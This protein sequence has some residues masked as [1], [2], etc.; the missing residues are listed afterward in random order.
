MSEIKESSNLRALRVPNT[1]QVVL[2]LAKGDRLEGQLKD[3]STTGCYLVTD[4]EPPEMILGQKGY[5]APKIPSND[6]SAAEERFPCLV[7]RIMPDGL[8]L[9]WA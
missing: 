5:L 4:S 8:G 7:L 1:S 9:R 2:T 6:K 3:V